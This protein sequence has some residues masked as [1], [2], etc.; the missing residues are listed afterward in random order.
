MKRFLAGFVLIL[1]ALF[2][3]AAIAEVAVHTGPTYIPR[4]DAQGERDITVSN[5]IFAVAFAVDTAPPWG[6]A[7]GGI[8][9]IALWHNGEIGYDIASLADF[10]PNT[11]TNWPTSY[12]HVS[13]VEQSAQEVVIAV[14]RDWG[15]VQLRTTFRIRDNDSLIHIET[16]MQNDGDAPLTAI[17]S[18]Y[19]V[20]P[21]GGNMFG[22]PGLYGVSA[23]TEEG[24]LAD[25]TAAYGESWVLGLHAPYSTI[26][27]YGGQ[28]RYTQHDLAEGA[29]QSFTAW[30]QVDSEGSLAPLVEGDIEL[31]RLPHGT[32]SG[33]A[34]TSDGKAIE[35]P[36]VIAYKDGHPYAWTLG[37]ASEYDFTLPIGEYELVATAKGHSQGS[38]RSVTVRNGGNVKLNFSDVA[39]PGTLH[40]QVSEKGSQRPLD[41]RITIEDGPK[42]LIAY[43]GRSTLFTELNE[44]G[45]ITSAFAPGKYRFS[46]SAAGGFETEPLLVEH[47]VVSGGGGELKLVIES[48]AAPREKGWFSA[49]LHH[50]SD[51]LDGNTEA[52]YVLRSELAAGLDIAFLSDHDSVVNNARMQELAERRSVLFMAGTEMSPSWAHFNAFPVHAGEVIEIDPGQSTVQEIFA[53]ARRMGAELIEAN[54]PYMGYGYFNSRDKEMIPGGYDSSYELIEIE[55]AFHEGGA[56]RNQQTLQTVWQMW[57]NGERKYLAS[58]SDVHDVWAEPSGAARTYVY[59]DGELSIDRYVDGLMRGRSYVSQGPLI[60]PDQLFGSELHQPANSQLHLGY[61]VQAVSGLRS[62]QLVSEGKIVAESEFAGENKPVRAAFEVGPTANTWY[63]LVVTDRN[64]RAAYSNPIWV[65]IED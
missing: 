30:L 19:V 15:D 17:K 5:G 59:V 10:L 12:Q 64:G 31:N 38:R 54:H 61:T 45:K 14:E 47:E 24:A 7:R 41:A 35:Q 20:W 2:S 48:L 25:W 11:W 52:E 42:P 63:S 16:Q 62:V 44:V 46:V 56:E 57:T 55:A 49:D 23:A 9:D 18:G 22:I 65:T 28:D 34:R 43:F 33:Q 53:E 60:Y 3:A 4:G 32:V 39:A 40:V 27:E 36:A 29:T 37:N 50:H 51:V 58:G 6:V 21:D 8:I 26:V 13:V 1:A